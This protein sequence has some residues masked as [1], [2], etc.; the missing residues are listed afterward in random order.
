MKFT[1]ST[2]LFATSAT[3]FPIFG[4]KDSTPQAVNRRHIF[5]TIDKRAVFNTTTFTDLSI[6]G[7]VAGNAEEEALAKLAGLPE[8][9]STVEEADLEFLED[10]N[11]IAND[12]EV[13]A[14]NVAIE[15]AGGE[16]AEALEVSLTLSLS[17]LRKK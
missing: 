16:E 13:E 11:G 4:Q 9:L 6:S 5:P 1:L 7:G 17:P 12:A 3:A 8:D 15:S 14:F 2:V 10:V